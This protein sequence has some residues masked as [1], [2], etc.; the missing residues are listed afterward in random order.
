M[1]QKRSGAQGSLALR[2][3]A[4][5][6]YVFLHIKL[7][8]VLK[9]TREIFGAKKVSEFRKSYQEAAIKR[10]TEDTSGRR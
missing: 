2:G 4:D 8:S 10:I 6:K 1:D 3:E 5:P 9:V 7:E